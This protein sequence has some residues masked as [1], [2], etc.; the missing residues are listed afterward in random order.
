MLENVCF[1][2]FTKKQNEGACPA[3]G[4]ENRIGSGQ[5]SNFSISLHPGTIL[6][7]RFVVGKTL[8]QGGFGITYLSLDLQ[9][10]EKFAIKEF[11]PSHLVSRQE[12]GLRANVLPNSSK[13]EDI[14]RYGLKKFKEEAEL[15]ASFRN[16]KHI[17]SIRRFFFENNTGYFVMEYIDGIAFKDYVKRMNGK[18]LFPDVVGI[19][20]P[21]LK[22]VAFI[23]S[24]GLIH[25]DISPDNI[26]I[27][28]DGTVKLLDFGAAR[29]FI[30]SKGKAMTTI[31][32]PGFAPPEQYSST[33]RQGP[34]TDIYAVAG[35]MYYALTG[36]TPLDSLSR[37]LDDQ[38]IRPT[39][40]NSS[41]SQEQEAV[42]LKGLAI[43]ASMRYAS[44]MEFREAL[45]RSIRPVA[46]RKIQN[47][48]PQRQGQIASSVQSTRSRKSLQPLSD[49]V[50]RAPGHEVVSN[51]SQGQKK[52]LFTSP[53]QNLIRANESVPVPQLFE[54]PDILE[55]EEDIFL[56][57]DALLEDGDIVSAE[58]GIQDGI[59]NFSLKRS[60]VDYVLYGLLFV[61][62]IMIILILS[63]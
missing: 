58:R 45:I 3:C 63:N 41:I 9:S 49:S 40:I 7:G 14:F 11:Y 31:L 8:G 6:A 28:N 54:E 20:E 53:D 17:V 32:K 34:W 33:G 43:D 48:A 52:N 19:I 22:A 24:K 1:N 60:A 27:R 16:Q 42:L 13:D 36:K 25:R 10:G 39:S 30:Q 47:K 35:T 18:L 21:V 29:F 4:F 38:L 56:P 57:E 26:F 59:S 51:V 50:R 61:I 23:H 15:L 55:R 37:K 44:A 12:T 46:S 2:C 5:E 62:F